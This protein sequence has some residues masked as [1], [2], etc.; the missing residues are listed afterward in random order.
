MTL[1]WQKFGVLAVAKERYCSDVMRVASIMLGAALVLGSLPVRVQAA[2]AAAGVGGDRYAPA[3]ARVVQSLIEFTRWP[4]ASAS[5]RLCVVGNALH[6]ER[7]DGLRLT[8]GRAIQRRNVAASAAAL[9]GCEVVYFGQIAPA[10]TRQ[11]VAAVRGKG[12]L[13]IAENDPAG[14]SEAMFCLVFQ[15]QA[16]SFKLNIDAIS[17]SGLRVDP[18]VLRMAQGTL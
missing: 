1:S 8:D 11:L 6:D 9:A 13:T 12:V 10:T 15:S 4:S 5:P 3:T 2:P 7:F 17:R 16:V 18:R 14:L